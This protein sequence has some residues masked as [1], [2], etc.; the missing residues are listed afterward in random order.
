[1]HCTGTSTL[2]KEKRDLKKLARDLRYSEEIIAKIEQ[3]QTVRELDRIMKD[4]R[5]KG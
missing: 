5:E 4:A 3:A 2:K 1:M